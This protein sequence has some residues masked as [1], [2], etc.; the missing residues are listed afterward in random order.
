[1][2]DSRVATQKLLQA[3]VHQQQHLLIARIRVSFPSLLVAQQPNQYYP[4]IAN[5]YQPII[6]TIYAQL[7]AAESTGNGTQPLMSMPSDVSE[8]RGGVQQL[9]ITAWAAAAPGDEGVGA[10]EETEEPGRGSMLKPA[11]PLMF[12]GLCVVFWTLVVF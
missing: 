2:L 3:K 4:K 1:M 7:S 8:P 9:G 12:D 10:A 11:V 6:P 5:L